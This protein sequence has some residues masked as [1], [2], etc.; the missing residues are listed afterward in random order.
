M[1]GVGDFFLFPRQVL[2]FSNS[3]FLQIA[4]FLL[5]SSYLLEVA[6]KLPVDCVRTFPHLLLWTVVGEGSFVFIFGELE[7]SVC[8][9]N[10]YQR[11]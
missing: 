10:N 8:W 6:V 1:S 9:E 2:L 3:V 7:H 5:V 11:M 4:G